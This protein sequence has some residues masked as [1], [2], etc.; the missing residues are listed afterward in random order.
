[1]LACNEI[2]DNK[3]GTLRA[4]DLPDTSGDTTGATQPVGEKDDAA[5]TSPGSSDAASALP[6]AAV[7]GPQMPEAASPCGTAKYC[8]GACVS[9]DDPHHG[10]GAPGCGPCAVDG[11]YATCTNGACA[12]GSCQPG[13]ADCNAV[14][15][16][17]CETDLALPTSC[18]SCGVACP[19]APNATPACSNGLC[20]LT[21]AEGFADCNNDPLDGCEVELATNAA[22]CGMCNRA[23]VIGLCV[24]GDCVLL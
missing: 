4:G 7:V 18:G 12:I 17:G 13:R 2:L 21:C 6:D 9:L 24:A 20:K 15:A 10:C 22:N 3:K 19:A 1:L 16:D 11:A 14:A 5:T 23:C 8:S